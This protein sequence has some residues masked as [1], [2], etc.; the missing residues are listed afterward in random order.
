MSGLRHRICDNWAQTWKLGPVEFEIEW[1]PKARQ[2]GFWLSFDFSKA[3]DT[4]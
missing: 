4:E 3:G 1:V 2:F